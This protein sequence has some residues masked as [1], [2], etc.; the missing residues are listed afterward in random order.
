MLYLL[1]N[2]VYVM[3]G[4]SMML[5]TGLSIWIHFVVTGAQCTYIVCEDFHEAV[6]QGRRLVEQ[7]EAAALF[8]TARNR[9]SFIS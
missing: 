7:S 4:T 1:H 3:L 6:L 5:N 2:V 8:T 9:P